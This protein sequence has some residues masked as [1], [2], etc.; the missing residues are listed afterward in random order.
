MLPARF[1]MV[2]PSFGAECEFG[3]IIIVLERWIVAGVV[4]WFSRLP[5]VALMSVS[6]MEVL[7]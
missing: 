5:L 1:E 7:E 6:M 4:A 3:V 2:F